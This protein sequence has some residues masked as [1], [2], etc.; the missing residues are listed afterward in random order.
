MFN[1]SSLRLKER[2]TDLE[3]ELSHINWRIL[4]LSN[5]CRQNWETVILDTKH[6]KVIYDPPNILDSHRA[7]LSFR[8]F[9]MR[10]NR[11]SSHFLALHTDSLP[12]RLSA[13][14]VH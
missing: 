5:I 9:L 2:F 1:A 3:V 14:A 12:D 11:H 10:V 4:G 8:Q 7:Q 13:T 6:F